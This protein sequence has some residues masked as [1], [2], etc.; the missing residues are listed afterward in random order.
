MFEYLMIKGVNDSIEHAKQLIKI[1]NK[2]LYIVNLI[3]YNQTGTYYPSD[4][5]TI[6]KFM[7]ILLNAGITATQRY[8]FGGEIKA[9][10][11]QLATKE[12]KK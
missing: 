7:K 3:K 1:I 2:P 9:A 4:G 6:S 5:D 12:N 10:C 11:G 8:S